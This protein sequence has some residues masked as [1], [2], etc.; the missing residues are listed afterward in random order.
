M[1]DRAGPS[2]RLHTFGLGEQVD[3]K[4]IKKAAA[5]GFGHFYLIR[6]L[7][8]IEF[9]VIDSLRKPLLDYLVLSDLVLYDENDGAIELNWLKNCI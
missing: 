5:K 9:K 4:L 2:K 3:E 7:K 6:E 1:K 8:D